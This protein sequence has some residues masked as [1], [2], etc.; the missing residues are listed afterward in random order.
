M[1][2]SICLFRIEGMEIAE[3]NLEDPGVRLGFVHRRFQL[4][5]GL[6]DAEQMFIRLGKKIV[7]EVLA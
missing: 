3:K 2:G 7:Q 4:K 6:P 5:K 1:R